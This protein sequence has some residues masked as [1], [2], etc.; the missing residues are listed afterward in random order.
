MASFWG[1]LAR[2]IDSVLGSG[3][4]DD[5]VDQARVDEAI[6]LIQSALDQEQS[7]RSGKKLKVSDLSPARQASLAQE[8]HRLLKKPT[9]EEQ[10]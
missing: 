1:R 10:V 8:L 7:E 5:G 3:S 4:H 6:H 2:W 9:T